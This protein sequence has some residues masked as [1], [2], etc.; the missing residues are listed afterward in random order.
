[1]ERELVERAGVL[2]EELHHRYRGC[3]QMTLKAIQ[4]VLNLGNQ[5][6]FRAASALSGGVARSGEVCGALLGA[7]MAIGLAMGRSRLEVTSDSIEYNR[8]MEAGKNV[9][10]EFNMRIGAVRCKDI[11]VKLF[12]R[13][14][15]LR[16][17][18][19]SEEFVRSG[20]IYRCSS[21]CGIAARIAV[22][23]ILKALKSIT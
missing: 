16:D 5:G 20:A 19:E 21:I 22:E 3:A 13:V 7:I 12:G 18:K 1:M 17:P 10:D 9:F 6:V 8:A 23:T 2:A 15:N 14:Y 11:H 4:E